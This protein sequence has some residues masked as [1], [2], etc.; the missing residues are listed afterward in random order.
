MDKGR[1]NTIAKGGVM[2]GEDIIKMSLRDVQRLKVIQEAIDGHITQKSAASIIE[3]S[4]RQVRRLVQG[5]AD[6][7]WDME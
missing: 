2:A 1:R 7:G 3:L 5:V 6:R 4:E